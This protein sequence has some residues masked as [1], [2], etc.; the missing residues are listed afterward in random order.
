MV[1]KL[2]MEKSFDRVRHS[3]LLKVMKKLGF[4]STFTKWIALWIASPWKYPLVNGQVVGFFKYSRGLRQGYPLS[5]FIYIIMANSLSRR[6][7]HDRE[8]HKLPGIRFKEGIKSINHWKIVDENILLGSASVMISKI[9]KVNLENFLSTSG[10]AK[11]K[12]KI[13]IYTWNISPHKAKNIEEIM[14]F[15]VVRDW[16]DFNY[17]GIPNFLRRAAHYA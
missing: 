2:D 17:L 11:N 4:D 6:W 12:D 1:T 5:P 10:A 14:G 13:H 16:K 7:E 15:R 9:F 3:F 8:I